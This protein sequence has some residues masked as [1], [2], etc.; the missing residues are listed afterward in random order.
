MW[1][2]LML[3]TGSGQDSDVKLEIS[4]AKSFACGLQSLS[5]FYET[6]GAKSTRKRTILLLFTPNARSFLVLLLKVTCFLSFLSQYDASI[7]RT[8]GSRK[9]GLGSIPKPAVIYL[10]TVLLISVSKVF[11]SCFIKFLPSLRNDSLNF[12][13]EQFFFPLTL[14]FY[15][16]KGIA[17]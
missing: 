10:M 3:A 17:N 14:P 6:R 12:N 5:E 8:F 2:K 16:L 15:I 9:C 4:C 11:F 13:S 1:L 7:M